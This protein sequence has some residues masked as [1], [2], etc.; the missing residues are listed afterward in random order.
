M[1]LRLL[2]LVPLL[3]CSIFI[4]FNFDWAAYLKEIAPDQPN[5][6]HVYLGAALVG[7]LVVGALLRSTDRSGVLLALKMYRPKSGILLLNLNTMN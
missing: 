2:F 7:L 1:L 6:G 5:G 3:R 4:L